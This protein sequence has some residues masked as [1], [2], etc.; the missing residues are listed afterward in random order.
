MDPWL[1]AGLGAWVGGIGGFMAAAVLGAG[2][3]DRTG[4]VL[5]RRDPDR[6]GG[7]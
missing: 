3:R 4:D 1:A 2:H 6:E 7:R 5:E